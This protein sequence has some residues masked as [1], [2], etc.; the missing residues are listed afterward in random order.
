ME[1]AATL[2]FDAM[3]QSKRAECHLA[4]IE[5]AKKLL[6]CRN[7]VNESMARLHEIAEDADANCDDD[8]ELARLVAEKEQEMALLVRLRQLLNHRRLIMRVAHANTKYLDKSRLSL[9]NRQR[10][11]VERAFQRGHLHAPN[12]DEKT[13]SVNDNDVVWD[14][15]LEAFPV[16][17]VIVTALAQTETSFG[18][19]TLLL[20]TKRHQIANT[21]RRLRMTAPM[22]RLK[23]MSLLSPSESPSMQQPMS[24]PTLIH[25]VSN[26]VAWFGTC[27]SVVCAALVAVDIVGNNWELNDFV[28]NAKHF[29][30]PLLDTTTRDSVGS[31]YAFPALSSPAAISNVGKFMLDMVLD[32]VHNPGKY[33]LLTMSSFVILNDANDICGRLKGS[34]PVDAAVNAT[35]RL[36]TIQDEVTFVRGT[37]LSHV[38]GSTTTAPRAPPGAPSSTLDA[39]GYTPAR[40][41]LDMRFTTAIPVVDSSGQNTPLNVTM[42][43]V[44][45]KAFCSGCRPNTELGLDTCE[46]VRSYNDT[47][48]YLVVSSSRATV[49][50]RHKAGIITT[51]RLG[52]ILS[53]WVRLTSILLAFGTF[54]TTKKT[55]RWTDALS[56]TSWHARLLHKFAPPIHRQTSHAMDFVYFCVNSDVVVLAY[57]VATLFDED[58]AMVYARVATNWYSNAPFDWWMELRLCALAIRW[59]WFNLGLLKL[60][61]CISHIVSKHRTNGANVVMGCLNFSSV[62]WIY[63]TVGAVLLRTEYIEYGNSVQANVL[64]TDEDL[65]AIY[66]EFESSWYMRGLPSLVCLLL[67]NLM[68]ILTVDHVVYW[69]WWR[70]V[71]TNSLGRQYMFNSTSIVINKDL[72]VHGEGLHPTLSIPARDL[73]TM[74][75]FFTSHLTCFGLPEDPGVVRKLVATKV[76]T[77][78]ASNGTLEL[79]STGPMLVRGNTKP[80]LQTNPSKGQVQPGASARRSA[81]PG[82]ELMEL[83]FLVQDRDGWLRLY[84]S[85]K[86][87]V[88]TVGMEPKVLKGTTLQLG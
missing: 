50:L 87:E 61:K 81:G 68:L 51:R 28:G 70:V 52:P 18:C 27:L 73:S 65:E 17:T 69:R 78:M 16:Q 26:A 32:Q 49:G 86:R 80:K 3:L 46:I 38:F 54:A 88:Q 71:A 39:M 58:V 40:V 55:V 9:R 84:D 4:M 21:L 23:S 79:Q 33:Y 10:R 2:V 83:H 36:G 11:L 74:Q 7:D 59:L 13:P 1:L 20:A 34:Y 29:T 41:G 53:L 43:R 30:T 31:M 67:G 19:S 42:Y 25:V 66:V 12:R 22:Q 85:E 6:E 62:P 63:T 44:Y 82:T 72:L 77:T 47:T 5:A 14:Q 60:V 8:A 24:R 35:V 45:S 48:K 37:T 15:R 75:W 64:S 57:S 76:A 56:L